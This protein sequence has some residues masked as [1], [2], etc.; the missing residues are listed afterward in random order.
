MHNIYGRPGTE[1]LTQQLK[2]QLVGL[3][4]QYNDP[5]RNTPQ[6]VK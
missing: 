2:K 6:G 1:K 3:Q 5:I 4:V